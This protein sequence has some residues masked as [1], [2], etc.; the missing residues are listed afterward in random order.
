MFDIL[1]RNPSRPCVN[2]AKHLP[3]RIRVGPRT[4]GCLFSG[5]PEGSPVFAVCLKY[6]SWFSLCRVK[7]RS[8]PTAPERRTDSVGNPVGNNLLLSIPS[9]EYHRIRPHLEF[10]ELPGHLS[11]HEPRKKQ[12]FLYF[13]NQGLASVVVATRGGRD[14][15]AGVVGHEGAVGV[16]LAVGLDSSPL[17]VIVQIEGN[18]FGIAPRELQLCLRTAPDLQMRLNR[19]AVLQGMLVAQTAACNRLHQV[20]QRLARW[21]LMAQD[22]VHTSTLPLTHDFLA[23]MLGTDRPSVSLAAGAL[24]QERAIRCGRGEVMV[25]SR[26][27]LE[28]AACE[29]YRVAQSLNKHLGLK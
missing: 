2:T 24:E 19:Y 25:V 15:E 13:L 7:Q 9:T 27:A 3:A 4:T 14:V 11:I 23:I 29:C 16:T 6:R 22:R 18:A 26:K 5:I 8:H 20:Q 1:H 12:R 28:S 17:R 21:L 10:L